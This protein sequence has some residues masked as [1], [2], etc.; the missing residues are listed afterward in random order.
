MKL[1]LKKYGWKCVL[2]SAS[3]MLLEVFLGNLNKII[4]GTK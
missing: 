3:A 2:G 1:S 4:Y